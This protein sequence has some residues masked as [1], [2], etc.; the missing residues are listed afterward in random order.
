[1][2]CTSGWIMS[3]QCKNKQNLMIWLKDNP[4]K[5]IMNGLKKPY[6][7]ACYLD[8]KNTASCDS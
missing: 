7:D 3:P 6:R 4:E 2:K 8:K 5:G 1:M